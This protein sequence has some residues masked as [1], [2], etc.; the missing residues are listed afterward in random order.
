MSSQYVTPVPLGTTLFGVDGRDDTGSCHLKAFQPLT[1]KVLWTKR[2]FGYATVIRAA[3]TLLLLGTEGS[4]VLA[5]AD[6]TAYKEL[7]RSQLFNTTTRAL[8]ALAN[9]RLY[10]RDTKTLKCV[11]VGK[12]PT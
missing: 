5:A 6:T 11:A 3:D 4:L 12:S 10:V 8:P 7:A 1:G 9:G 2:D